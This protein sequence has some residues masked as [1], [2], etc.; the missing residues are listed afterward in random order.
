M[1]TV[2]GFVPNSCFN[3]TIVPIWKN[4]Y[5]NMTDTSNCRPVAVATDMW[6][7]LCEFF[8]NCRAKVEFRN[9]L[10][11]AH[12]TPIP[13]TTSPKSPNDYRPICI[14]PN[15]SKVFEKLIYS[16]L[17]SFVTGK[18]ILSPQQYVSRQWRIQGMAGMARAM[19]ATLTGG[20]IAW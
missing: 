3:T 2:Y 11:F 17:Y 6:H 9:L 8:N 14:H 16:R 15:L 20:E 4:K 5:W 10:K 1:C 19:G 18:R 7:W 12:I 13:E